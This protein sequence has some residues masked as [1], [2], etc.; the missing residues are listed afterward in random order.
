MKEVNELREWI[1][2]LLYPDLSF[3]GWLV[4]HVPP[5]EVFDDKFDIKN[6]PKLQETRHAWLDWMIQYWESKGD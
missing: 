5:R 6:F 2:D 3:E 1:L 4:S